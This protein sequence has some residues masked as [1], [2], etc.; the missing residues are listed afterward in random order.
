MLCYM[1]M[2]NPYYDTVFMCFVMFFYGIV[3][4]HMVVPIIIIRCFSFAL[5]NAIES[6]NFLCSL[7]LYSRYWADGR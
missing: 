1:C 5:L 7:R 3:L 4:G 2:Y 6:V